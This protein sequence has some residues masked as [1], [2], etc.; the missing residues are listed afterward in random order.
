ME[1][2]CEVKKIIFQNPE[3]GYVAISCRNVSSSVEFVARGRV[4]GIRT[5]AVFVFTGEW[6]THPKYGK[7]FDIESF[8]EVII[9]TREAIFNYLTSG[10]F[11]GIGKAYAKK[12]VDTF[13]TD[14]LKIMDTE[15][16]RLT[17]VRG[18][19]KG[20][21]EKIQKSWQDWRAIKKIVYFFQGYNIPTSKIVR[22]YKMYGEES[23]EKVKE[24][25]YRLAD[26]IW[27]FGFK[28]ADEIAMNM[29]FA[30]DNR[31]RLRSGILYTLNTLASEGHC[32][33][34]QF[35]LFSTAAEILGV[36]KAIL[37]EVLDGMVEDHTVC[38]E[39]LQEQAGVLGEGMELV[40][41][42]QYYYS[43]IGVS[44]CLKRIYHA[45]SHLHF[46][47]KGLMQRVQANGDVQYDNIQLDA[48][49]AAVSSKVLVLTGG[50]GTGKTTTTLGIIHAFKEANA[51]ILLAAPT[52]KAAKRLAET[53]GMEAKTIHRLLGAVGMN[54][55]LF[56]EENPLSGDVLIVD[57]CS[58]IDILLMHSLLKAVPEDMTVILVGDVDQLPS[59]G[60]GNV[61]R[62]IINSGVFPVVR[63]TR[64]F[65]QAQASRIVTGAHMVNDGYTPDI[66][67]ANGSDLFFMD[68]DSVMFRRGIF[69]YI[70][71]EWASTAA[72]EIV[73]LVSNRISQHFG[74]PSSDI[75]VLS[76]MRKGDIG[77]MELN[78]RLQAALNP[79]KDGVEYGNYTFKVNDR[80]M[81]IKN[82]YDKKV[83][84]GD[85]GIVERID[86]EERSLF[87]R[88]EGMEPVEYDFTELDELVLSYATTIHK[89][90]GSEYPVVVMPVMANH[91]MM[92]QRN[93]VYTGM[94]RAKKF[95]V[96]VGTKKA[97]NR[98]VRNAVVQKRNTLLWKRLQSKSS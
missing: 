98:A 72:S 82:N 32:F 48:I 83:F 11:K 85:S 65:R 8:D 40:Y 13:G 75:Q 29:G 93:L 57:E 58:M 35:M 54:K 94:T 27:G 80:V 3:D 62:D 96:I 16:E 42:K 52:G 1:I 20:R 23:I 37:P 55:F 21:L 14:T 61:L 81:Q 41:L 59:V 70:P 63:L 92:L 60:A 4:I 24:N 15:P 9:E 53:T 19:G 6:V 79:G 43:E 39:V 56:N 64:I 71:A 38:V 45:K 68:M 88:F 90:Q 7:Q 74:L 97:M 18:I 67:N 69:D 36:D 89:S 31:F 47:L 10:L 50:P 17:E 26:D 34:T 86:K 91:W 30:I 77:V 87:V 76:P 25:P 2:K 22:I 73:S 44:N 51:R 28:T 49:R 46:N 66:S 5:G 95:L 78:K 33:A 84:N 12:I